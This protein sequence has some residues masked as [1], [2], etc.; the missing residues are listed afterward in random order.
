MHIPTTSVNLN[1]N[2]IKFPQFILNQNKSH[3]ISKQ[4]HHTSMTLKDNY[5]NML[6]DNNMEESS[7]EEFHPTMSTESLCKAKRMY[8]KTIKAGKGMGSNSLEGFY[9]VNVGRDGGGGG[10]RSKVVR[11]K[12]IGSSNG[13]SKTSLAVGDNV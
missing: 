3:H 6:Y 13:S 7:Y 2:L 9:K 10:M 5:S 8:E 4:N 12:E 11:S 1:I